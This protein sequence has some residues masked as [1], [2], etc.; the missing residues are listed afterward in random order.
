MFTFLFV[1]LQLSGDLVPARFRVF[2][3]ARVQEAAFP[4]MVQLQAE[5]AARYN[6]TV[7]E[8]NS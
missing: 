1:A 7:F 3:P 8:R 2:D 5:R 6:R 4:Q